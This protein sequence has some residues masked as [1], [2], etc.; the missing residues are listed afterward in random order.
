MDLKISGKRAFISG[1]SQ[2]IGYAIAK[3]L[4]TEGVDVTLNGGNEA[5]LAAAV[6]ALKVEVPGPAL[7]A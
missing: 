6:K 4:A 7:L 1:S 3:A 2:G 5:M